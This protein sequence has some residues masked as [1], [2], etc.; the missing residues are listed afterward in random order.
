MKTQPTG[1]SVESYLES[2]S[3]KRREEA[4]I[5]IAL[6][7]KI[8]GEKPYMWGPSIIAFGSQHYRYES[9]REGDMPR[10]AFSP[11][12]AS[13]TIYF[14][15]FDRY[16]ELLS[17]LGKHK[18]S[19]SCLYIHKLTDIKLDVLRKMLEISFELPKKEPTKPTSVEEYIASIPTASRPKFDQLR[20]LVKSKLPH[21]EEVLSYGII[22]YKIDNKRARVFISGWKDH[23]AMY[24][25][26]KS[27]ELQ[28]KLKPY[29]KGKGTLWFNLDQPL[30][31]QLIG[32][33]VK[34]L[35]S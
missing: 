32:Q 1:I 10:L 23:I 16:G 14:E 18:H 8:S 4:C 3:D 28:A 25:V 17:Q 2:V 7:Q 29:I 31:R 35:V 34:Y 21:A 22:G 9:G 20:E 13:I 30:P 12:K 19:V 6:M 24:P 33:V 27:S 15:G 26:P 5:L 11:R